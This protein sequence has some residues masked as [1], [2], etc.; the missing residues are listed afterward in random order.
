MFMS[1]D[2]TTVRHQI[3]PV[4]FNYLACKETIMAE[5]SGIDKLIKRAYKLRVI[6]ISIK[7]TQETV[8]PMGRILILLLKSERSCRENWT[9]TLEVPRI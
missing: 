6:L 7:Y 3:A 4:R 2:G 5:A 8:W 1:R 9:I